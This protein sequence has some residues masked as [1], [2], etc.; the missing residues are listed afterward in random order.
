[1]KV[2]S[3]IIIS[4]SLGTVVGLLSR[5][6]F[7]GA[8]CFFAGFILDIDH[9]IEYILH[10]GWRSFTFKKCYD[11]C[12]RTGED[13]EGEQFSKLHLIF[14][15]A[16]AAIFLWAIAFYVKSIPVFAVALGYSTHL[17]F[18]CVGN[19]THPQFYFLYWRARK[20]FYVEKLLIGKRKKTKV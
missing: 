19:S 15:S 11:V 6:L 12:I 18:D 14:H 1:M 7:A 8:L 13:Q 20:K 3:H 5:S 16:E 4:F 9:I 10:Y 2:S 17:F